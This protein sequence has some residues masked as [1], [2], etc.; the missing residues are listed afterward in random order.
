MTVF[1]VRI[2]SIFSV[3]CEN[4]FNGLRA[5]PLTKYAIAALNSVTEMVMAVFVKAVYA[6]AGERGGA[7]DVMKVAVDGVLHAF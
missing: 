3:C 7:G 6:L 1:A 4:F 2:C 5:L